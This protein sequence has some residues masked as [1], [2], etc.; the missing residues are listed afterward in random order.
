[1]KLKSVAVVALLVICFAL[2]NVWQRIYRES[3][4]KVVYPEHYQALVDQYAGQNHLDPFFV[5]AVIKSESG[6]SP[7][8]LSNIGAVGLMQLTPDTFS[9]AQ[10][11]APDGR[12]YT[13]D[14][15]Y[16]PAVNIKYGTVVLRSLKQEFGNDGTV[17]AAYHAGR[18]KVKKWLADP[19][20]SKDGRTLYYIPF[21]DTRAYVGRV[22]ETQRMY[23]KLYRA[24]H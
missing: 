5:Y 24:T 3:Y 18:G 14:D 19:R 4:L 16:T 13:K 10:M 12:S 7:D 8:A 22:L 23:E 6:F 2:S 17:L 20:Y 15:L 1:M 21:P 11:L 9:W